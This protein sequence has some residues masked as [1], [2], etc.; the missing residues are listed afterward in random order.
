[1]PMI[2]SCAAMVL[3]VASLKAFLPG[4]AHTLKAVLFTLIFDR[5]GNARTG[6]SQ[7]DRSDTLGEPGIASFVLDSLTDACFTHVAA[8]AP[9]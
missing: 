4:T 5:L 9:P 2:S 6:L 1:M 3:R 7:P 8:S